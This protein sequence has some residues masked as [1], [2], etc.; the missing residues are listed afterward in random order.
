MRSLR[1]VTA[2]DGERV[3]CTLR[4]RKLVGRLGTSAPAMPGILFV[5]APWRNYEGT[6]HSHNR[7]ACYNYIEIRSRELV[8]VS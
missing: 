6:A 8:R 1:T 3:V 5:E 4:E 2:C 7:A